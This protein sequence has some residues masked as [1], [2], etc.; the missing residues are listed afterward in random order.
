MKNTSTKLKAVKPSAKH[1]PLREYEDNL[2]GVVALL[3]TA[4]RAAARSVN[5]VMTAIY[6]ESGRRI[7]KHEQ[8]GHTRAAYREELLARLAVDLTRR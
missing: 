5:A 1:S 2:S 3:A 4:R 8:G 6:G 7:V